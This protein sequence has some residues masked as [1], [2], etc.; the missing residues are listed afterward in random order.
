MFVDLGVEE[1]GILYFPESSIKIL[2]ERIEKTNFNRMAK[3]KV[4]RK[5]R[6]KK[7]EGVKS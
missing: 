4:R 3:P 2:K 7:N 1:N 6:R 5:R